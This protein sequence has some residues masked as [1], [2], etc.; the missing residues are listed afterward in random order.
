MLQNCPIHRLVTAACTIALAFAPAFLHADSLGFSQTNLV[1]DIPR[2]GRQY[3]PQPQEPLGRRLFGDIAVLDLRSR[4]WTRHSVQRR[5][6]PSIA[7]SSPSREAPLAPTGPTGMV[8][9]NIAGQFL[10]TNG[11]AATFIFDNLNGIDLRLEWRQ[12]ARPRRSNGLDSR[13]YLHWPR[14]GNATGG[15]G[16]L[17][18][19]ADSAGGIDVFDSGW[20]RRHQHGIRGKFSRLR[21]SRNGP[22]SRSTSR[23]SAATST[24]PTPS[25][26]PRWRS[27]CRAASRG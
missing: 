27:S 9:S 24:S 1:S 23:T 4:D 14:P 25:S 7:W 17:L 10:L 3:R 22:R 6:S 16:T 21:P 8:F 12:Q 2:S 19:A 18:Y 11:S 13:R 5:R 20:A 26:G 15:S